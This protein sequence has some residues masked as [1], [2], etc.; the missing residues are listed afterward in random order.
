MLHSY[1]GWNPLKAWGPVS[2]GGW[3]LSYYCDMTLSQEIYP[4]G[5]QPSKVSHNIID[6]SIF[7]CLLPAY[8]KY[9][10][11]ETVLSARI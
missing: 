1:E 11:K 5:A 10:T 6:F 3:A 7:A 9:T 4:M 2:D 8:N